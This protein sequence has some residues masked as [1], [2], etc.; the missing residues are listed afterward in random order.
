M[1]IFFNSIELPYK[2][3]NLVFANYPHGEWLNQV[4]QPRYSYFQAEIT[5]IFFDGRLEELSV[6][7]EPI[8]EYEL[9]VKTVIYE[10]KPVG[11]YEGMVKVPLKITLPI[12]EPILFSSEQELLDYQRVLTQLESQSIAK[13]PLTDGR[14]S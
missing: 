5:R 9:Q 14:P 12:K 1:K 10:L 4:D 2:V 11:K 7:S 8:D 3:G 13:L 6:I